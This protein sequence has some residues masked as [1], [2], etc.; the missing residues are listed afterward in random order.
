M[1]PKEFDFWFQLLE[2]TSKQLYERGHAD[3][4][5]G[6]PLENEGFTV[7]KANRLLIKTNLKKLTERR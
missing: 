6:K 4:K 7:S 3:G 5:A 2:E 1:T